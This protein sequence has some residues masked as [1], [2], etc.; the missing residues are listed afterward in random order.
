MSAIQGME[1]NG[2]TVG[3]LEL[4]VTSWVSTVEGCS[5]SRVPLYLWFDGE[6]DINSSGKRTMTFSV[7][8]QIGYCCLVS[9]LRQCL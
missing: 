2:K 7:C 6:W 3:T 8:T 5:L 1:V 4:S 9:V